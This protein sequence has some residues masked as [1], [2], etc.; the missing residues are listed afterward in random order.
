MQWR[1]TRLRKYPYVLNGYSQEVL[2]ACYGMPWRNGGPLLHQ[3]LINQSIRSL[4][5]VC[6]RTL[7]IGCA[8]R[9]PLA[10]SV[11]PARRRPPAPW[12]PSLRICGQDRRAGA[13][14]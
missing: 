8:G 9:R 12:F 13:G 2:T 1:A 6:S 10:G 5:P 14:R 11:P 3:T 4:D 7:H